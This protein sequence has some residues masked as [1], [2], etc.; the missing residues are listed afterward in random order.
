MSLP[1]DPV[2]LCCGQRHMTTQCPDGL[3]MCALC[4]GRFPIDQLNRTYDG[5]PENVCVNC[6]AD[7]AHVMAIL[8]GED[9]TV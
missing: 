5:I 8:R 6:A 7:E 4:F 2:L 9:P 1:I 3:T